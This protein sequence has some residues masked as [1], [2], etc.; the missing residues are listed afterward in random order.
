MRPAPGSSCSTAAAP[1]LLEVAEIVRLHP[2][3]I[4]RSVVHVAALR[5]QSLDADIRWVMEKLDQRLVIGS[6]MPEYTPAEAF[7][8][9]EQLA[10]GLAPRNGANIRFGNLE[11]LFPAASPRPAAYAREQGRTDPTEARR[12]E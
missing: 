7:E 12:D 6:D 1:A 10:D 11:R 2:T 4:A 9:A 8:R 3:L 5:R